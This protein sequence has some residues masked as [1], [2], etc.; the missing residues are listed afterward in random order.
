MPSEEVIVDELFLAIADSPNPGRG[1]LSR[2]TSDVESFLRLVVEESDEF[3]FL[4]D[5]APELRGMA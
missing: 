2:F 1:E 4:W 3:A 5:D